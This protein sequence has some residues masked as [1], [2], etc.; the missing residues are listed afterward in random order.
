[1]PV[2][3]YVKSS[4]TLLESTIKVSELVQ[5]ASSLGYRSIALTDHH[6]MFG[7]PAFLAAC[8]KENMHGIVGMEVDV[9]IDEK[10]VPFLLLAR[11]NSG[12]QQLMQLSSLLNSEIDCLDISK[13]NLYCAHCIVIAYGEGGYCDSEMIYD[14]KDKCFEK[15]KQ[16]QNWIPSFYMAMSYQESSLWKMKNLWLKQICNNLRIPTVALNKVE[17]LKTED[18]TTMEILTGIRLGQSLVGSTLVKPSG[19]YLLDQ[20]EMQHLY[21]Q[22]DLNRTDEIAKECQIDDLAIQTQLPSFHIK[23]KGVE[24]SQY[25]KALCF[26]GLKKRR[27]GNITEPYLKRLKYELEVILRMHFE[28]YFLIVYDFIR[29][30]RKNGIQVGPGRGSAVGSLVA[31]SLG[32]TMIDPLEYHL[33]FERF[34]NTE[35]VTMPDIDTDIADNRRGE[36]ID[37]VVN[38]YGKDHIV[39]IVTF[40]TFGA[41]QSIKDVAKVMNISNYDADK[42]CKLIPNSPKITLRKAYQESKKLQTLL[43]VEKKYQKLF[44]NALKIEGLPRHTSIHAAGIV[45]SKRNVNEV[46]PTLQQDGIKTSQYTMEYLEE[47][48]LIKMDFLGLRNLTIVDEIIKQI[49]KN[50]PD[51]SLQN[52]P[53]DDLDV[54]RLFAKGDTVGIFQ[55]ESEGIKSLLYQIQPKCFLD[56]VATN[57]L[58]RPGPMVNIPL[59]LKNRKHPEQITYA[60]PSLEPILKETNGIMIYQEQVMLVAQKA[61]GF[62]L[63]KADLLRRAIS[64]KKE[65]ELAKMKLDFLNGC[66]QNGYDEQTSIHLFKDIE[67]F[68][69]YGFNKSHSV[70]YSLLAYQMAYLKKCYPEYFYCALLNSVIGNDNKTALYIDEARRRNIQILCPNINTSLQMY[71]IVNHA[72]QLPLS[73]IK[74]IG[75]HTSKLILEERQRR[76]EYHDYFDFV[77]RSTLIK[78]KRDQIESLIDSGALD[79]FQMGRLTCRHAL[80][81]ALRYASLVQIKQGDQLSINLDLVTTPDY[82]KVKDDLSILNE[83]ERKALGFTLGPHPVLLLKKKFH[84]DTLPLSS[85]LEKR[86]YYKAVGMIESIY[87]HRTKKGEMMAFVKVSDETGVADLAIM[88]NLYQK[89]MSLLVKGTYVIF[90]AK[91]ED[92]RSFLVNDIEGIRKKEKN[93]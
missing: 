55:F 92:G 19:R 26:A 15:L 87:T 37:Y 48:G 34:L 73:I 85:L 28:D 91:I 51:F 16:L 71:T 88:P 61:A 57:A 75:V 93:G 20:E 50:D 80:D 90:N 77:A 12:Y 84:I 9:L 67:K 79:C 58:Y 11:D 18:E 53:M 76:N 69:G 14:Q 47:R 59:Y 31:Y 60:H 64:K 49:K 63:S 1:M 44:E 7:V 66:K 6:V 13:L 27:H 5:Y 72:I 23:E 4:Y 35:R 29:F 17:Y 24:S 36:V 89:K 42:V 86:G 41:R 68:A 78:L 52:I 82:V 83:N 25:L 2:H 39:N 32:I 8:R 74:G 81:D 65:N 38:T 62:S 22:D 56:L 46:I 10:K 30:A 43:Q 40:G 45:M 54:Y 33:L 3:L 70:A 21:Q